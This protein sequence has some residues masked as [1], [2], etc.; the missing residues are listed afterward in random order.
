M[1]E[2]LR[3]FKES[4]EGGLIVSCQPVRQGPFDQPEMVQAFAKAAELGGACALRIESLRDIKAVRSQTDLPIIGLVKRSQPNTDVY[5]TPSLQDVVA[6]AATGVEVV[7][8]DATQ[9]TRPFSV[10]DMIQA[11]HQNGCLAMADISTLEEGQEAFQR[12]ADFIASTLSG[13]TPA[14]SH[15][16]QPNLE[17]IGQLAKAGALVVAEG[18]FYELSHVAQA[19]K[20]GAFAVTVGTAITRP[21]LITQRFVEALTIGKPKTVS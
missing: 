10:N 7:A 11:I 6:I 17:L 3:K 19:R 2:R 9:R 16:P 8:F 13:N 15:H 12:G 20:E 14:T 4:V 21:E 1:G 5:I 18:H